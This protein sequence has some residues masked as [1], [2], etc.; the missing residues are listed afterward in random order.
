MQ[1]KQFVDI[2]SQCFKTLALLSALLAL[3]VTALEATGPCAAIADLPL[4]SSLRSHGDLSG[5]PQIFRVQVPAAGLLTLDVTVPGAAEAEARLGFFGA[6]CEQPSSGVAALGLVEQTPT[7]V[8]LATAAPGAFRVAVA[9]QDPRTR[10][11]RYR[12]TAG[13]VAARYLTRSPTLE[14]DG[15]GESDDELET[16]PDVQGDDPMEKNGDNPEWSR[17][18]CGQRKIDDHGDT[19]LCA[20]RLSLGERVAGEIFNSW[21]DDHD[22]FRFRLLA[23]RT[24]D[25]ATVGTTDTFGTL[26]SHDGHRL[27]ADDDGGH[28]DNFR[29][30]K[31]LSPGLYYVQVEGSQASEGSYQVLVDA[32]LW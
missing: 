2:T 6:A 14:K 29:I 17:Q 19:V 15:G 32:R 4:D 21:G 18:L 28:H 12:V 8:V 27:A 24:V 23:P 16:E 13:F 25:I 7:R 9:A 26:Y 3:D 22:L 10:L 5:R 11:G 30:V 1:K 31:T 20:T